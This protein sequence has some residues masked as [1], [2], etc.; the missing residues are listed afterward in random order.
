MHLVRDANSLAIGIM[1]DI[2]LEPDPQFM[3][4]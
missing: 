4:L 2:H 1:G 3:E